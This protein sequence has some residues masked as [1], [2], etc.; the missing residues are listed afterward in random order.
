M[1]SIAQ[2]FLQPAEPERSQQQIVVLGATGSIGL[3][4]LDVIALHPERYAVHTLTA[5]Q[6]VDV[7]VDLCRKHRPKLV[8]MM[9]PD[10]AER[11]SMA[12]SDLS[13]IEVRCGEA[14]MMEA[15][16]A[17]DVDIVIA[18]IVGFA[19]LKSVLAAV[20]SGKRVLLANKEVLVS[21]GR[22]FMEAV[23]QGGAILLPIDSEHNA[24]FQCIPVDSK[25]R[26][27][28]IAV[29]KIVL[30]A[31][32]GPFYGRT[33]DRL[34]TV[35]PAEACN[36]PNWP[37]GRKISVDSATMLNK[38]LELAEACWLF[39]CT[40][41]DIEVVVH[42]QSVVHS[43][44]RYC[45]GSVLAQLSNPDMRTPIAYGLAWPERIQAGI[46]PLD[47]LNVAKLDFFSPDLDAFPCLR[48]AQEAIRQPGGMCI[49]NAVNEMAVSA[50]LKCE[51]AFTDI[52]IVIEAALNEIGA[53]EP[54]TLDDVENLDATARIWAKE[55][56]KRH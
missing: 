38:G 26:P 3:S 48:L 13:E 24:L 32:G 22:V 7:M 55:W 34:R 45:D 25:A 53:S 44:V 6:S 33:R 47:L 21:A 28:M 1:S 2:E 37:M 36:H 16:S 41:D 14:E 11:L 5:H 49:L 15:A 31:S 40:P 9:S 46:E 50:F 29:E 18:A 30:T 23:R 12:I 8:V 39:D 52:D 54:T 42:P 56:L 17:Q 35:T 4:A 51:L 20:R 10:A 27:H 43:L 19:G